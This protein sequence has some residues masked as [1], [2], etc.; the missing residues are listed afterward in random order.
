MSSVNTAYV[1]NPSGSGTDTHGRSAMGAA[2]DRAEGLSG[3]ARNWVIW[4]GAT[5]MRLE[6]CLTERVGFD[7]LAAL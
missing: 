6:V 2:L 1:T 3:F 5:A 7:L 4:V